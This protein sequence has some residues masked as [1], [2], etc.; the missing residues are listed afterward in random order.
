MQE[1]HEQL[2]V[3]HSTCAS[4][5]RHTLHT[6]STL[7]TEIGERSWIVVVDSYTMT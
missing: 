5:V 1:L 7:E 3:A 2:G 6:T 4:K